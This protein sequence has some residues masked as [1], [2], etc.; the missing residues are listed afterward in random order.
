[1]VASCTQLLIHVS[2]Q[3]RK[4]CEPAPLVLEKLA[5]IVAAQAT[6]QAQS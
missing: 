3:T 1:V 2:L 4:S 6:M 5:A